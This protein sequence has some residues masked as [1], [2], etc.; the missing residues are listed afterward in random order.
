[1]ISEEDMKEQAEEIDAHIQENGAKETKPN[2]SIYWIIA[3]ILIAL[4]VLM[5]IPDYFV[6]LD[7]RPK[8]V[9]GAE[10]VPNFTGVIGNNFTG[11]VNHNFGLLAKPSTDVKM[12]ADTIVS[13]SCRGT[14]G[15]YKV[16][17]AKA[18]FAFVQNNVMYIGDPPDEF[19]KT[20]EQTLSVLGGD[21]D[22]HAILLAS[23]LQSV[24][25][26]TRFVFVPKHVYVSAYLPDALKRYKSDDGWVDMDAT[27]K[28][29]KFGEISY[30][31]AD[32]TKRYLYI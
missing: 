13:A 25:I 29:C 8:N 27:C 31:Y 1:M 24:G 28:H 14:A 5:I 21:C 12:L 4:V 32:A 23:L 7:P 22:D 16:C 10:I 19:L 11:R 26:S 18:L 6:K 17:H 15:N 2:K 3:I 30:T 9:P 20:P